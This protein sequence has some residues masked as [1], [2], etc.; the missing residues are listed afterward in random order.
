MV[1]SN[2]VTVKYLPA[3]I[4][5]IHISCFFTTNLHICGIIHSH[6]FLAVIKQNTYFIFEKEVSD[7]YRLWLYKKEFL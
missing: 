2:N 6:K 5:K 1:L 4:I 3:R 7:F